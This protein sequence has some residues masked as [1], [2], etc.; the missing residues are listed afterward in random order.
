MKEID[1]FH[2]IASNT[3]LDEMQY[4]YSDDGY[5]FNTYSL[6]FWN[7]YRSIETRDSTE[8]AIFPLG[9]KK[10]NEYLHP[11]MMKSLETKWFDD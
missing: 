9:K 5:W 1:I 4:A 11:S 8:K 2:W 7:C 6:S 3:R 10:P